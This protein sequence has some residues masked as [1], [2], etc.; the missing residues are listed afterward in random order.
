M[1]N[2]TPSSRCACLH[3]RRQIAV[4][5]ADWQRIRVRRPARVNGDETARLNNP[6]ERAAVVTDRNTGNAFARQGSI[7]IVSP[8]L[9]CH[10]TGTPSSPFDRRARAR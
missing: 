7:V 2:S 1:C 10:V 5:L 4:N 8:S 3:C 9:K 6:V